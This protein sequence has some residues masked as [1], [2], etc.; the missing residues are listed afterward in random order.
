MAPVFIRKGSP[1]SN[2]R[3]G[4]VCAGFPWMISL[5]SAFSPLAGMPFWWAAGW[6]PLRRGAGPV[7]EAAAEF[8]R[9]AAAAG[10]PEILLSYWNCTLLYYRMRHLR[11]LRTASFPLTCG[12]ALTSFCGFTVLKTL[13]F[14]RKTTSEVLLLF[15]HT[16]LFSC[17]A[18]AS[19]LHDLLQALHRS[20]Q[21]IMLML[22]LPTCSD[23][24]TFSPS[25]SPAAPAPPSGN[26][27]PSPAAGAQPPPEL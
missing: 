7:C 13:I 22:K 2:V 26:V 19:P 6:T 1:D 24:V 14:L 23:A 17:I 18:F 9:F 15:D 27:S 21:W 25:S 8:S 16:N 20:D 10:G 12:E 11:W 4:W 5:N 3:I